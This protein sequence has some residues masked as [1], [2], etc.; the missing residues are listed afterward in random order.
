VSDAASRSDGVKYRDWEVHDTSSCRFDARDQID[1][2]VE[3]V[4]VR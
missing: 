3:R 1:V 2:D 4:S